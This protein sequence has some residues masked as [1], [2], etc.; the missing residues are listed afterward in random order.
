MLWP[1]LRFVF[2]S[3]LRFSRCAISD[4]YFIVRFPFAAFVMRS[5]DDIAELIAEANAAERDRLEDKVEQLEQQRREI[6][7]EYERARDALVA[8]LRPVQRRVD[9]R[10]RSAETGDVVERQQRLEEELREVR[11]RFRRERQEVE[12]RIAE[13]RDELARVAEA[14]GQVQELVE[15]L[16]NRGE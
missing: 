2:Y 10:S 3:F 12:R 1:V 13:T 8:E 7:Q 5:G 16:G 9:N 11:Q 6:V 14:D 4:P 15:R